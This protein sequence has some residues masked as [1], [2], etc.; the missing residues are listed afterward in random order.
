MP[1]GQVQVERERLLLTT[2]PL[3]QST[4]PVKYSPCLLGPRLPSPSERCHGGCVALARGT[5]PQEVAHLGKPSLFVRVSWDFPLP[6]RVTGAAQGHW[7]EGLC[8]T[9]SLLWEACWPE[10][11]LLHCEASSGSPWRDLS[12]PLWCCQQRSAGA[13]AE[14]RCKASET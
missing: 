12:H 5:P 7:P 3:Q 8:H 6:L 1:G 10:T 4:W 14:S 11:R 13:R 9:S 2:L